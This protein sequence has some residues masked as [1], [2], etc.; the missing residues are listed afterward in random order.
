MWSTGAT[1]E[2][3]SGLTAGTY[4]VTITDGNGCSSVST[5]TVSL[6]IGIKNSIQGP[7]VEVM[8]NPTNGFALVKIRL[9]ATASVQL[10]L[11]DLSGKVIY[12]MEEENAATEIQHQIDLSDLSSGVYL[13]QV[14]SEGQQSWTRIMRR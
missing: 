9:A 10:R 1:T 11:T 13:L 4:T 3:I 12:A 5:F 14:V 6:I 7:Q 8:P 2:D